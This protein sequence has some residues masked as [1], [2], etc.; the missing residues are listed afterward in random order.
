[1]ALVITSCVITQ[2]SFKVASTELVAIQMDSKDDGLK[3][4]NRIKQL[5]K[6]QVCSPNIS[7]KTP[8]YIL[9]TFKGS[10]IKTANQ[11]NPS[12]VLKSPLAFSKKGL[13]KMTTIKLMKTIHFG[14]KNSFMST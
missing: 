8:E 14:V 11:E 3:S 2:V 12:N 13:G 1:M 5:Y 6:T 7:D 4:L 10:Q 9:F